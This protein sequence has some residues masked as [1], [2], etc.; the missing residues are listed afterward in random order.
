VTEHAIVTEVNALI[1]NVNATFIVPSSRILR[2]ADGQPEA[3][4]WRILA[5]WRREQ[6]LKVADCWV[7]PTG[8]DPVM[9]YLEHV[10]PR[11]VAG[12]RVSTFLKVNLHTVDLDGFARQLVVKRHP[13]QY[14]PRRD[15]GTCCICDT[16][17]PGWVHHAPDAMLMGRRS[18]SSETVTAS[19]TL[20]LWSPRSTGLAV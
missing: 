2:H 9:R 18:R 12:E 8:S 11:V 5:S 10:V 19:C 13:E 14:A 3:R 20:R 17:G 6:R 15:N 1:S 16:N 4:W 7:T